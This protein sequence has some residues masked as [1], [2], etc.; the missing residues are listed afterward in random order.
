ME[1][2]RSPRESRERLRQVGRTQGEVRKLKS[3]SGGGGII[4]QEFKG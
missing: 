2:R 1:R 4:N 3:Q